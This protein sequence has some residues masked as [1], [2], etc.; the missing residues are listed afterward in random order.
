MDELNTADVLVD[1]LRRRRYRGLDPE[2]LPI[3]AAEALAAGSDDPVI[4]ELAATFDARAEGDR[5]LRRALEQTGVE[6][7]ATEARAAEATALCQEILAGAVAPI[8]NGRKL[9]ALFREDETAERLL[10]FW[11]A[12]TDADDLEYRE[13][14][15]RD[16]RELANSYLAGEPRS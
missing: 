13:Q 15:E 8:T 1:L 11:Q 10:P 12:M 4:V 14:L 5:A 3:A 7:A 2:Q 16:L 6:D 9:D